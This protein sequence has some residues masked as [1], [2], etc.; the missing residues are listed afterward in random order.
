MTL[1]LSLKGTPAYVTSFLVISARIEIALMYCWVIIAD[2]SGYQNTFLRF[3]SNKY[4]DQYANTS[5]SSYLISP[6]VTNL[7]YGLT[8]NGSS[9]DL[10]ET[11]SIQY[12]I[13]SQT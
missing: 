1:G 10:T 3:L 7:I 2:V 5:Y 8:S 11:V 13:D 4:F 6:I 9:L 12:A